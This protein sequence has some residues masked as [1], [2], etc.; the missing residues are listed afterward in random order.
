MP[1]ELRTERSGADGPSRIGRC[2]SLECLDELPRAAHAAL[3]RDRLAT[4]N[5]DDQQPAQAYAPGLDRLDLD[6]RDRAQQ[7][8]DRGD[9][10]AY[11][12]ADLDREQ[13]ALG[14]HER[15]VRLDSQARPPWPGLPGARPSWSRSSS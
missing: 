4:A 6:K 2:D 8:L 9:A 13:T 15:H 1:A 5:R 12:V 10:P 14:Q 3:E 11:R 7:L